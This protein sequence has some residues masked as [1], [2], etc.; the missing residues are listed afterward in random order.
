MRADQKLARAV[1]LFLSDT[2]NS[3]IFSNISVSEK[4]H[5]DA[6]KTL[7][8]RYGISDPAAGNEEGEFTNPELQA[9]YDKLID[10]G[11][12]SLINA[13]WVGVMIEETDIDD[14]TDA[15]AST[16][17]RDIK[18]VYSNLLQG[19]L[20]HLHAFVSTLEKFGVIYE[21]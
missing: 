11:S 9:L 10:K 15:I 17:R 3:R 18:S 21:P 14:L 19:S 5:M 1:Y 8:D 16:T 7:L 20:N 4:K 6:I 13:L 2:W 12:D